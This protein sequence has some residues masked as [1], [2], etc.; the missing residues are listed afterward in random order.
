MARKEIVLLLVVFF[1]ANT[2]ISGQY[3]NLR[4]PTKKSS[5]H[6]QSGHKDR[7]IPFSIIMKH[8]TGAIQTKNGSVGRKL[9]RLWQVASILYLRQRFDSIYR[10]CLFDTRGSNCVEAERKELQLS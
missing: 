5:S 8:V 3:A 2:G 10:C 1:D 6:Q 7:P 9:Q 4:A